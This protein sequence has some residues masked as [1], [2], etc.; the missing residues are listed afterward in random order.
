[1]REEEYWIYE[2]WQAGLHKAVIHRGCGD[3][4]HSRG[5]HGFQFSMEEPD[6]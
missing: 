5:K 6:V 4:N 3:C 1:V 2:N